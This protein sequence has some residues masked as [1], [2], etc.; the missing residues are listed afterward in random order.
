MAQSEKAYFSEEQNLFKKVENITINTQSGERQLSEWYSQKPVLLT[1]VFSRCTGICSP[2]VLLLSE[3]LM[4]LKAPNNFKVIVLSFDPKDSLTNMEYFAKRLQLDHNPQWF[5]GTTNEINSI[6]HQMAFEYN[7]D[8]LQQQYDHDALLIGINQN[9]YIV[10]KM[11]GIRDAHALKEMIAAI[12]DKFIPSHPLPGK[13]NLF[14]CFSYD[15]VSGAIKPSMGLLILL[16]PA[17]LTLIIVLVLSFKRQ[18][19]E[20]VN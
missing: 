17:L 8:S 14:S 7:W 9:G 4:Q 18:K 15:P 19:K 12:E 13:N 5:F 10:K 2:S 6:T 3:H 11:L 16:L 20:V 1:F